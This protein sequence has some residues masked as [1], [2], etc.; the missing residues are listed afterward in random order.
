[1]NDNRK[2]ATDQPLDIP[3]PFARQSELLS[4]F[5]DA[6][7]RYHEAQVI[8]DIDARERAA[9]DRAYAQQDSVT[10]Q[11]HLASF[12]LWMLRCTEVQYPN[13]PAAKFLE[14]PSRVDAL[15]AVVVQLS[16]DLQRSGVNRG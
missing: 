14:L 7:K 16:D 11:A 8:G 12:L 4:R 13:H 1:M 2:S 6:N 10:L 9:L 5:D 15:E 3:D